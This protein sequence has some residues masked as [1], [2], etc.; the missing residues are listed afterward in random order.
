MRKILNITWVLLLNII[1]IYSCTGDL[2]TAPEGATFTSDQKTEVVS[3]VPE[4]LSADINGMYSM[5]SEQWSV[6]GSVSNRADDFGYPMACLSADL[7]G[8]DMVGTDDN[9]NWF[10]TAST[11]EDRTYTYANPYIRWAI[12]YNQIKAT[13]D[14]L[15][16][17]PDDTDNATLLYYKGQALAVRAFDYFNLVQMYQFTYKGNE[18]NPAVPIV[19]FGM[20]DANNPRRTVDEIYQLILNDLNTAI[21]LLEGFKRTNKAA[22]DKQVALGI[23][24]RVNLV[25]QNWSDAA[26]DA[27][28]ARAEYSFLSKSDVSAPSFNSAT[29]ESWMWALIINPV[30]ITDQYEC[31]PAKLCSF[32]GNSYSAGVGCYKSVSSLLWSMIPETDVR[33][34]WW[35][36]EDL[37]S[38][39]I[40]NLQ[41]P[42]HPGE[43]IGPLTISDVKVPFIPYTNVKFGPYN[44]V[45][46]NGE[47]ASDWCIMRAEE[48]LLIEAEGKAMSGD[49][50]GAKTL[51]E[52]FIINYR[53]GSYT[54]KASSADALQNEIW[55]QRR[56]E[57]W[58]EGFGFSDM[59]RLKRNLVRFNN[60]VESNFP[61]AF[62]FNL[63][64]TDGWLLLRIPQREINSNTGIS[65]TDNNSGGVLPNSGDGAG[66]TDGVTD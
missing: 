62:K 9:Y 18:D 48:M 34:G 44:N 60:R 27:E 41:W 5:M 12:Y 24:A 49:V 37:K 21:P 17:I 10:S 58:G 65:D 30:N 47:N 40:N 7:N 31:W 3:Q 57:L 59:M 39:L 32:A 35:V 51:L 55:F 63:A 52:D 20:T 19:T 36:D 38:P 61:D 33:K 66:L 25:M 50:A 4:R 22:V 16:S 26:S 43:A 53:D 8:P 1:T 46:G 2:D 28:D 14:I 11:Y 13:N 56:V 6:F 29:A 54:S 15:S 42:G 64:S 23:R 45:L